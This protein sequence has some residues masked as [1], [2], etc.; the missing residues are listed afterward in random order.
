[1]FSASRLEDFLRKLIVHL[2][3]NEK[4]TRFVS[5]IGEDMPEVTDMNV[6]FILFTHVMS[7]FFLMTEIAG[8][9]ETLVTINSLH[10]V[11]IQWSET[12]LAQ[13]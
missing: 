3:Q 4:P 5:G 11:T 12:E 6:R 8:P 10:D 1:L 2:G 13:L 7:T 9:S